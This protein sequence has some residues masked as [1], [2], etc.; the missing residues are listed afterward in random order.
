MT[1]QARIL[2]CIQGPVLPSKHPVKKAC[3][4]E[5]RH[6]LLSGAATEPEESVAFSRPA[7]AAASDDGWP[8]HWFLAFA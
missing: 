2:D 1:L 3:R 4:R 5:L 8:C 6:G 7:A